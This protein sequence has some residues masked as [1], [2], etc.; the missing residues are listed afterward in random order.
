MA[1]FVPGF[2]TIC[3]WPGGLW[4]LSSTICSPPL[5]RFGKGCSMPLSSIF[6][7]VLFEEMS[8]S[9]ALRLT[10]I[11]HLS[12][13]TPQVQLQHFDEFT[14][15]QVV[16]LR[17]EI[18]DLCFNLNLDASFFAPHSGHMSFFRISY[19]SRSFTCGAACL[20]QSSPLTVTR[21]HSAAEPLYVNGFLCS[22][23]LSA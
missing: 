17:F 1:S 8:P 4:V 22:L 2:S 9:S 21:F 14:F 10:C 19:G 20:V 3:P 11:R 7:L 5:L 6:L 13:L 16:H 15:M 23:R 12:H 18:L